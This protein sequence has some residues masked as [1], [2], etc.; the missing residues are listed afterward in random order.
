[1]KKG[2][3]KSVYISMTDREEMRYTAVMQEMGEP[4]LGQY[5]LYMERLQF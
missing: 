4:V 1:M 5:L 3:H 2:E